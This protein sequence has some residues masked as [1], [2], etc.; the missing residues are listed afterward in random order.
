MIDWIKKN[1]KF[2]SVSAIE[3]ELKMP[4]TTLSK[5]LNNKQSL[6]KK[7]KAPL[8]SFIKKLTKVQ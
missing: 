1:Q 2:L 6:P 8:D 5:A 7:W 4:D 3:K